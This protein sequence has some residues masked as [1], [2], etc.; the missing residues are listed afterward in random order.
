MVALVRVC[1]D[2]CLAAHRLW[3]VR[4]DLARLGFAGSV[5]RWLPPRLPL[6]IPADAAWWALCVHRLGR[7]WR[8]SRCLDQSLALASLL[9][10]R[11]LAAQMLIGAERHAAGVAAHAWVEIDGAALDEQGAPRARFSVLET[12]PTSP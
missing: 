5:Q 4:R 3:R 10:E 6:A 7:R 12:W 8:G 11:G 1:A 9:R 2:Y